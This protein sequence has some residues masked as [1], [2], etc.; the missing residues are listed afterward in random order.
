M[1]NFLRKNLA[2]ILPVLLASVI[3]IWLIYPN[4]GKMIEVMRNAQPVWMAVSLLC[5]AGSY[6]FM[7]LML[8][9]V[10][11]LLKHKVN[12][13]PTAA[14][15]L[16]STVINYFV[17]SA[18]VSGFATRVFY[19][20]KHG[21]PYGS[22]VTSSVVI[23][24]L[25]YVSLAAIVAGGALLQFVQSPSF[26]RSF[27]ESMLGVAAVLSFAS[28]LTLLFFNDRLRFRWCRKLYVLANLFVYYF[29]R[30]RWIPYEKF[31]SFDE[32]LD[33]GISMVH[34][35]T[36]Y[37]PRLV[38]YVFADWI[39]NMLVLY[40]AFKAIGVSMTISSLII[41][42]AVGMIMTV[43]PILPGGLGAMEAAMTASFSSMGIDTAAAITASLIF[44][45][46]YYIIPGVISIFVYWLLKSSAKKI[47]DNAEKTELEAVGGKAFLAAQERVSSSPKKQEAADDKTNSFMLTNGSPESQGSASIQLFFNNADTGKAVNYSSGK[48]HKM[49]KKKKNCGKRR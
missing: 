3:L 30:R 43:I 44:R 33:N 19:L 22:C 31:K 7:S 5:A 46:F 49:H 16:V 4:Y 2:V 17:S 34:E 29:S 47:T 32:Q 13:I 6:I 15:T 45:I 27:W 48:K 1:R 12:F 41:G 23:T 10:L 40:Y 37:L 8:W 38:F 35:R 20:G 28:V 36:E 18:G 25:I 42:F 39:C 26:G 11:R 24:V 9:D 21:V 14:I